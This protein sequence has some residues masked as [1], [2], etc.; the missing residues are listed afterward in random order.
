MQKQAFETQDISTT[1]RAADSWFR[2]LLQSLNVKSVS[3]GVV[4]ALFGCSGPAL[5]VISAAEAGNLSSGQTVAWLLAIYFVG[6][7]IS[8]IMALRYRQPVTG[9]YSI[10]GAAIMIG[11]LATIP[12]TEAVG[13]FIMSGVIVLLLGIS[14]VVGRIMSWLP[15]PI[16]MAMI[17]GALIRFGTGAVQAVESMPLIA[18]AA[19]VAF[20]ASARLTKAIPP[21]LTAAIV[22]F[23][24]ALATGSVQPADVDI[25]FVAPEMTMPTFT[26]NGLLAIAI[27]LAALVIGAENAQATGV[28]MAEG[29]KPPVNAMTTISGIGGMVAGVIGG[30]NANIAGPMTAICS[31]EQA[32]DDKSKRYGATVVNGVLFCS[33][34]LF[35]GAAV[36]F[37][38]ALPK[39]LIG[40]VAGLAMI[41]VLIA[42]FQQ[43]FSKA[44]GHQIGSMVALLVAMSGISLLGISS[45]FWAL[46]FG[47]LVSLLLSEQVPA[48]KS[49]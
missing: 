40:A 7:L 37:I 25:A 13:A 36:P 26:L 41:G 17:A 32:G 30:H 45:P 15:M 31:S 8:L 1:P 47:I 33:F 2:S 43:A 14:G 24:I 39:A 21:V 12:F 5:I 35:A 6:G 3:A 28:L 23:G 46:V 9:A 29:Y 38:L 27:P 18:G 42:A 22:G 20:F 49:A 19:A 48:R 10:P 16:V 44:A 11:A 4:A 34:G